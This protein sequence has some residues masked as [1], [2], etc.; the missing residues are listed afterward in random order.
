MVC[1]RRK[2]LIGD[3]LVYTNSFLAT[4]NARQAISNKVNVED[5]DHML[6]SMPTALFS[7][8]STRE[9]G[10]ARP[11]FA[12]NVRTIRERSCSNERDPEAPQGPDDVSLGKAATKVRGPYHG[13]QPAS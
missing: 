13:I 11:G 6:V 9:A 5:T 1:A 10:A 2:T 4:L 12:I 8:S 7:K 3:G